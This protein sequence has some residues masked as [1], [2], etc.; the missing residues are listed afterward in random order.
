MRR[1]QRHT[2]PHLQEARRHLRKRLTP[3]E[4]LLWK[5]LQKSQLGGRKFQ[6]Q[7]SIENFV[8][9]FYCASERLIIELDGHQ[10]FTS[11]GLAKDAERDVRLTELGYR[12]VRVENQALINSLDSVIFEIESYFGWSNR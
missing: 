5:C 9:D 6:R 12:V 11:D 4:A 3:A 2:L 8:V 10:H 1:D 7:H